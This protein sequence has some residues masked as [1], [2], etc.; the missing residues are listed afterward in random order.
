[1]FG[2]LITFEGTLSSRKLILIEF[3]KH[4][5]NSMEIHIMYRLEKSKQCLII[6]KT[7][8]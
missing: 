8:K 1:M 7:M 5:S 3:L 2:Q 4:Y 6:S